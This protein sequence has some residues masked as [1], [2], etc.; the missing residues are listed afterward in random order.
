MGLRW[1]AMTDRLIG[2]KCIEEGQGQ[3][4]RFWGVV[5]VDGGLGLI[6][7]VSKQMS[8]WRW[9]VKIEDLACNAV[10]RCSC[11]ERIMPC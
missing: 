10:L 4:D 8:G 9:R 11:I 1:V 6:F 5:V 7:G 2:N 3:G